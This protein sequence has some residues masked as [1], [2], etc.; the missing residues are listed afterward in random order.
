MAKTNDSTAQSARG[1]APARQPSPILRELVDQHV[2]L[3]NELDQRDLDA[4]SN[5]A[6]RDGGDR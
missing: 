6:D 3:L 4:G 2:E 1:T 5:G